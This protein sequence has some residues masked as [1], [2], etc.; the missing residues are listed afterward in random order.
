MVAHGRA[1]ALMTGIDGATSPARDERFEDAERNGVLLVARVTSRHYW[2][3][4][5]RD[6][7]LGG[8]AAPLLSATSRH[9]K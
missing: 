7:L 2:R 6:W 1:G 3:V 9:R 4:S 8:Q 5:C